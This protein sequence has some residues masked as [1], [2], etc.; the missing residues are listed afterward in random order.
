MENTIANL[1]LIEVLL[2][3]KVS[4]YEIETKTGI[5]RTTISNLRTGKA[6]IEKM[7]LITAI[8]LTRFS[9]S[10]IRSTAGELLDRMKHSKPFEY[11]IRLD[12][13]GDYLLL[14]DL[15]GNK[16]AIYN[17]KD[18]NEHFYG[19]YGDLVGGQI[20]S[21]NNTDDEIQQAIIKMLTAG[22]I[23]QNNTIDIIDNT[24]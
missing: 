13:N 14:N 20:D 5:T 23:V 3:S 2:N 21:R 7:E 24:K 17:Y 1:K 16:Q 19:V 22:N 8:K 12:H 4:A 11:N 15:T 18:D 9:N 6:K 10:Q